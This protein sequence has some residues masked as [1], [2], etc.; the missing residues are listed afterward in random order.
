MINLN[1]SGKGL[2]LAIPSHFVYG[3]LKKS[4]S[5]YI[6]STDIDYLIVFTFRDIGQYV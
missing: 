3:F 6:L 1:F 4:F 5:C 2:G